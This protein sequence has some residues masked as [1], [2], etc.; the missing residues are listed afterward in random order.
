MTVDDYEIAE[1]HNTLTGYGSAD[2]E[3]AIEKFKDVNLSAS[4]LADQVREYADSTGTSLSRIDVCYVAY[5]HILQM[6][7]NE[8][9]DILGFDICND[10]KDGTEFYTSGNAMCTSFDY[11]SEAQEQLEAVLKKADQESIE[12]LLENDF[13]RVFL[14]DVDIDINDIQ[15]TASEEVEVTN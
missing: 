10:I 4:E 5:N 11:S 2:V 9:S 6:A 15:K 8:I 1:F 13:V 7:R 3:T 14:E 12:E